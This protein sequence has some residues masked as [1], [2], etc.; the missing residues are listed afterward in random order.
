[1][2]IK[3]Y[4]FKNSI[5]L[6]YLI[7]CISCTVPEK[8]KPNTRLSLEGFKKLLGDKYPI[9]YTRKST[10][11]GTLTVLEYVFEKTRPYQHFII[12]IQFSRPGEMLTESDY[13]KQKNESF[14]IDSTAQYRI[15][16]PDVGYRA[17]YI[18]LGMGPGGSAEK[19]IFTDT[20]KYHDV[21][22]IASHL[23]PDSV[24]PEMPVL[25]DIAR[26][27]DKTLQNANYT[28]KPYD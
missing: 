1:M 8:F 3:N 25:E 9:K 17:K 4:I 22:I 23:L 14:A 15:N 26:Y 7:F 28:E 24:Q 19:I 20:R 12:S 10:P 11:A 13:I 5:V 6:F 27:I 18:F 16:Y 2:L 21:E